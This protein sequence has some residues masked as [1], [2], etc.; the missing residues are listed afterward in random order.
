MRIW[1]L[2]A[3]PQPRRTAATTA[4]LGEFQETPVSKDQQKLNYRLVR[5]TQI[6]V[7]VV[8][9]SEV[10]WRALEACHQRLKESAGDAAPKAFTL[11]LWCV[12]RAMEKHPKFRSTLVNNGTVLRTFENVNLG[13]AVALPNDLLV[14]AVVQDAQKLSWTAFADAVRGQIAAAREGTDQAN[15]ST[16]VMVSNMGSVGVRSGIAA[17]V[18]PA[19]ATMTLGETFERPVPTADGFTFAKTATICVTFDHRVVNGAGAAQFMNDLKQEIE[20]LKLSL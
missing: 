2:V 19:V 5:G 4:E 11:M 3:R 7:P 9:T 16:T 17:V 10:D 6:C 12:V 8:I 15:A 18:P 20:N 1:R 13:I 14:T